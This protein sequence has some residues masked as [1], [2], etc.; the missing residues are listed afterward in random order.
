[1]EPETLWRMTEVTRRL[2]QL[3]PDELEA[4]TVGREGTEEHYTLE[5]LKTLTP[6]QRVQ[7]DELTQ[8][9]FDLSMAARL[10]A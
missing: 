8:R 3:T 5:L 1:M 7:L 2:R 9:L 10:P 4:V 6:S